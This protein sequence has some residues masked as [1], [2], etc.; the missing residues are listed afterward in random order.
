MSKKTFFITGGGTG[1]HIYPA[2]AVADELIKNP[3]NT[4]Y[5]VNSRTLN[6]EYLWREERAWF[7]WYLKHYLDFFYRQSISEKANQLLK[8]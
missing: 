6:M 2:I 8:G 1:G 7:K 4:V 3:N 5:Y